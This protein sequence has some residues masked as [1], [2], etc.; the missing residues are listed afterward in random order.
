MSTVPAC[1]PGEVAVTCVEE[2]KVKPPAGPEPKL[3]ALAAE[4]LVP[5]MVTVVPPFSGPEMGLMAL[6]VGSAS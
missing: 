6:T 2:M 5:V 1:A 4:K 3:T